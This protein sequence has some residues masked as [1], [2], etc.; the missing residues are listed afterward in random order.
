MDNRSADQ[1]RIMFQTHDEL[2]FERLYQQ[3]QNL[4]SNP[5][6]YIDSNEIEYLYSSPA[7]SDDQIAEAD[8]IEIDREPDEI[9]II[10]ESL[11]EPIPEFRVVQID[12]GDPMR[13]IEQIDVLPTVA[14]QECPHTECSICL[15]KFSMGEP[16]TQL[17]CGHIILDKMVF[18]SLEL[19]SETTW[20]FVPN[21]IQSPKRSV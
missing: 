12:D 10:Y 1:S 18:I 2:E 20:F 21:E 13:Y 5:L 16:V 3:N 17:T 6:F 11:S 19:G 4:N 8:V 7:I 9:S 14:Y 15:G